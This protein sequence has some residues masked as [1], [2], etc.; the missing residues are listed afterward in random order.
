MVGTALS[1]AAID[2]ELGINNDV[3]EDSTDGSSGSWWP[4]FPDEEDETTTTSTSTSS[5]GTTTPQHEEEA[6]EVVNEEWQ[7]LNSNIDLPPGFS[8]YCRKY[9]RLDQGKALTSYLLPSCATQNDNFW[10]TSATLD[11]FPPKKGQT[12]SATIRG[13]VVKTIEKG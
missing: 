10:V 8:R 12:L 1:D 6:R 13:N 2:G 11:P 4:F 7:L 3:Q 5:P 9:I